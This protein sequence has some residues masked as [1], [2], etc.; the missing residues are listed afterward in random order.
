MSK[1]FT[2]TYRIKQENGELLTGEQ[3]KHIPYTM[4]LV[5]DSNAQFFRTAKQAARSGLAK[6]NLFEDEVITT[7]TTFPDWMNI[8]ERMDRV[9]E[10]KIRCK[11][12]R[13][14]AY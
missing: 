11:G 12:S 10:M 3:Q 6:Q 14:S 8:T 9:N 4:K 13:I 5:D 1:P 7:A 2:S